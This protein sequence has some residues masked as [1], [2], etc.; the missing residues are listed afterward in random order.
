MRRDGAAALALRGV[1]SAAATWKALLVALALNAALA[2]VL[3]RPAATAL[4]R[5]L[6]RSPW[7][8]R[9][10]TA[11]DPLFFS[12]FTRIRPDVLGDVGKLEDLVTGATPTGTSATAKLSSLLPKEGLAGS[13]IAFGLL[14]AALAAV[15]AGGFAGRFGAAEERT[16]LAAFGADCGKFALPSLFFGLLSA[17]LIVAAWRWIYVGTGL[18][19]DPGDFRYEWQAIAVTLLRLLAFL[20]VAGIVRVVVQYSRAAMGLSGS[21][22][23]AAALGRGL[24]FVLRHPGRT[25]AL[26]I[27][28]GA[29]GILPLVLWGLFGAA[30]DGADRSQFWTLLGLQQ[31]VVL[32]RIAARTAYLGAASAWLS[33]AAG[34]SGPAAAPEAATEAA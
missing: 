27:H 16:S 22:N 11:A 14:A 15:L 21:T 32:F 1:L 31:L 2:A 28:F 12:H 10:A 24:G 4:H 7:A 19:Y 25:L 5:T 34:D 33:R 6:D 23:V 30:W 13:A 20:A 3:V 17:G 29:A 8:D 18:L 26:E 9:M